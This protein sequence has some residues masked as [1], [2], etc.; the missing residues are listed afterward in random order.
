M[1]EIWQR[2]PCHSDQTTWQEIGDEVIILD[3]DSGAYYG[4]EGPGAR[5]W[6]LADGSMTAQAIAERIADEYEVS[7][8]QARA[9]VGE[10]VADL[11]ENRLLVCAGTSLPHPT[12]TGPA[13]RPP[14]S[15]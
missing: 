10:L 15:A 7:L 5:F 11:L 12:G 9:D 8:D 6:A 14:P 4:V 1:E 3:V 13:Q 2:Y